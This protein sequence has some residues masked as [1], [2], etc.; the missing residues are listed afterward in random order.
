VKKE[1]S[2]KDFSMVR[3]N[4]LYHSKADRKEGH[5]ADKAASG[6]KR[7]DSRSR[8]TMKNIS[9]QAPAGKYHG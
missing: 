6:A 1:D 3:Q 4:S 7:G 9:P 8:Q 5:V 2:R